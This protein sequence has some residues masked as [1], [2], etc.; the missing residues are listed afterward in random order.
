MQ[1]L[2]KLA[3][4]GAFVF[5]LLLALLLAGNT[6]TYLNFDP[7]YGFLKLKQQAIETGW[8]LPAYYSHVLLGGV[9]LVIGFF[10]LN[11][12]SSSRYRRLHRIFGYIYVVGILAF[13]AP[14][15]LVMSL[16]IG[17]GPWVQLSFLLQVSLWFFCTLMALLRI[18]KGNIKAHRQWM[19]RSYA[20]TLAAITLR[21]YIFFSS[22]HVDLTQPHAYATIAWLSWVPNLILVELYLRKR[23]LR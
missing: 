4:Y 14:G 12:K 13:A 8:Y 17:R 6:L 18:L 1:A 23:R 20:L 3:R 19:W 9:I 2:L 16:F 15:G 11:P 22:W 7:H 5:V 10:Q 21:V